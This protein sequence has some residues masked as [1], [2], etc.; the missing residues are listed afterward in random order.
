[1]GPEYVLLLV[2]NAFMVVAFVAGPIIMVSL[3]LGL[4]VALFQAV[5]QV[6]E[7]SL[8]F[9]PKLIGAAIM[10]IVMGPWMIGKLTDFTIGLYTSIP[11]V[12]GS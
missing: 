5:T 7:A 3:I 6:N 4:V 1:M 8:S 10:I 12:I 9:V 11:A 2:Q